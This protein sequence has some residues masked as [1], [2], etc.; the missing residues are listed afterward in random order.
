MQP[1]EIEQTSA[2]ENVLPTNFRAKNL[3]SKRKCLSPFVV[4]SVSR[5]GKKKE[6]EREKWQGKKRERKRKANE[7]CIFNENIRR[8]TDERVRKL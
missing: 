3:S 7:A 2:K 1:S 4:E 5:Q 8:L 6:R